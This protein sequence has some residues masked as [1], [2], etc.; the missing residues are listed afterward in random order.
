M[1]MHKLLSL[2]GH[3]HER[4]DKL[5]S[6]GSCLLPGW[7]ARVAL[8]GCQ[9]ILSRNFRA[10]FVQFLLTETP[11]GVRSTLCLAVSGQIFLWHTTLRPSHHRVADTQPYCQT[12]A[13][14]VRH[15]PTLQSICRYTSHEH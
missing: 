10:I 15:L 6:S 7:I 2:C 12:S 5:R 13:H 1:H 3:T 4:G 14:S 8:S 11:A 9:A